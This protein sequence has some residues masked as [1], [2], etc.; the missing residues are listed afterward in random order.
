MACA[1][2]VINPFGEFKL[3]SPVLLLRGSW[4]TGLG[5]IVRAQQPNPH[6][7]YVAGAHAHDGLATPSLR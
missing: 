6:G 4:A 3:G 7:R 1:Q 2:E 5:H